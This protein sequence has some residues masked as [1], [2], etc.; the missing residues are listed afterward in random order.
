MIQTITT[1]KTPDSDI[2]EINTQG[3]LALNALST[4]PIPPRI[5]AF[6][7]HKQEAASSRVPNAPSHVPSQSP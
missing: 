2:F 1:I 6:T 5:H 3:M 4:G 7:L